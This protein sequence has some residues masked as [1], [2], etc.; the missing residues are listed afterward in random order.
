[1]TETK[2]T[3]LQEALRTA[4]E[5]EI[6]GYSFYQEIAGKT[7]NAITKN[8]FNTLAKDEVMHRNAIE[9]YYKSIE[10]EKELPALDSLISHQP[11]RNRSIFSKSF[12]ELS[13]SLSEDADIIEAYNAAMKLEKSGYD[14]YEKVLNAT[15]VQ[16]VK[17]LFAFLL[18]EENQ[19]YTLL[20][21]SY[22][23]L[24]RPQDAFDDEERPFFEG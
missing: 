1:M 23:Y 2:I 16:E 4:I 6:K 18:K 22:D 5:M 14:F 13:A 11:Q 20:S 15:D 17:D 9:Q 19:H 8:I 10:A 3:S 7:S 24:T 21:N 12:D